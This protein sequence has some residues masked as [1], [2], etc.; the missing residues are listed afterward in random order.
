MRRLT[1][2]AA[3][4]LAALM[5]AAPAYALQDLAQLRASGQ[6]AEKADG[7]LAAVGSASA[8]VRAQVDAINIQRRA[9]YTQLAT[10]RGATIEE[11]AAATA[12]QIFR[13]RIEP[14]TRYVLEDGV[15]RTRNASEPVPL[16]AHCR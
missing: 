12:C 5:A 10:Q 13:G 7:Y 14:G 11:A 6:A 16:P 1:L 2:F 9:A 15:V 4:G 3:A 8:Q